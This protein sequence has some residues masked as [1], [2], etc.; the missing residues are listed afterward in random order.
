MSRL[1]EKLL[2]RFSAKAFMTIGVT[3]V[4]ASVLPLWLAP[5]D[6]NP[7]GL[8]LLAVFA[9]PAGAMMIIFGV[10]KALVQYFRRE[11]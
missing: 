8:G 11:R 9:V 6:S 4:A 1:E 2:R 10:I 5:K 3:I 7:I